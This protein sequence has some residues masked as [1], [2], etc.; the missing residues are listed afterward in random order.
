[1]PLATCLC[2]AMSSHL[3]P[4]LPAN[5]LWE[6]GLRIINPK[7]ITISNNCKQVQE[8]QLGLGSAS[9]DSQWIIIGSSLPPPS[10]RPRPICHLPSR[11]HA[12]IT[13][14]VKYLH[15]QKNRLLQRRCPVILYPPIRLSGGMNKSIHPDGINRY[16]VSPLKLKIRHKTQNVN[17]KHLR[18][19]CIISGRSCEP[20]PHIF[21]IYIS[22]QRT[23]V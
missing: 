10:G 8:R 4:T 19:Q 5:Q 22:F 16:R 7:V 14:E 11:E 2:S 18:C 23:T 17:A 21:D 6:L 1:M 15:G 13:P 9:R 3:A 12:C 20:S